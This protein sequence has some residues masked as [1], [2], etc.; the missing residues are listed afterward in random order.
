LIRLLQ[1]TPDELSQP[2]DDA[3]SASWQH[4]KSGSSSNSKSGDLFA[5]STCCAAEAQ[6]GQWVQQQQQQQQQGRELRFCTVL[7][8]EA[9]NME[10]AAPGG[11]YHNS[12]TADTPVVTAGP[13]GSVVE[14]SW[15]L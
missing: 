12:Q 6:N 2:A 14:G 1:L 10:E 4:N 3:G 9:A 15:S 5:S 11:P 8:A 7:P 13:A